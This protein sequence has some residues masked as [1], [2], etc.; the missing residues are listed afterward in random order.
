MYA[1]TDYRYGEFITHDKPYKVEI[2]ADCDRTILLV[3][4]DEGHKINIELD[5]STCMWL[6]D[7]GC[8]VKCDKDGNPI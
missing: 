1:K 2:N 5:G 8:W 3:C 7:I 4:D 6:D